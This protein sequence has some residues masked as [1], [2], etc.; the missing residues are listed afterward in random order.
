MRALS[1]DH[2]MQT[3]V[4]HAKSAKDAKD[5]KNALWKNNSPNSQSL[6]Q[7]SV[8]FRSADAYIRKLSEEPKQGSRG[9]GHPRADFA[10]FA[11]AYS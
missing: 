7:K 2:S 6:F 10:T 11:T 9:C 5:V 8:L 1:R 4:S 3:D